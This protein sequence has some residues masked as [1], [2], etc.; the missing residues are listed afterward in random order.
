[1][2]YIVP[3]LMLLFFQAG[4]GQKPYKNLVMEGGGI[5]GIAYTGAIEI[6]DSLGIIKQ[7]ERVGG[8]SAGAIEATMIAIGYSPKELIEVLGTIPL[9]T[10]NDGSLTGGLHRLKKKLGFYRSKNLN[11]WISELIEKK[12]G[13]SLITFK[14]LHDQRFQKNYKDL[15]ITGTDLTYRRLKIFS[16]EHYPGM[17]IADALRISFSIPFYFEPVFIND[18]GRIITDTFNL[19]YHLMVDGGL[20]NNYPVMMFDDSAYLSGSITV[21]GKNKETLG[22]MLDKPSQVGY[23]NMSENRPLKIHSLHDYFNAVYETSI[24]RPN[25]DDLDL[26]RTIVISDLDLNGR[27]RKLPMKVILN[28]IESGRQGA[29][30]FFNQ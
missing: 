19:K 23:V 10:F 11:K 18:S 21:A 28:L 3:F 29:R 6:L 4:Q 5:R 17:R 8:S 13:D 22:L 16:F 2:K 20:L 27:I 30:N 9:K 14:E 12:T 7:L 15:Y 24:D 25:P 26:K 1:M